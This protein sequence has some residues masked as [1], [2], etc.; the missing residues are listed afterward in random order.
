MPREGATAGASLWRC[1]GRHPILQT[2]SGL[3]PDR[4]DVILVPGMHRSGTS[5]VTGVLAKL[6]AAPPRKMLQASSFNERGYFESPSLM[7]FHD[8]LLASAG[9]RWDDWQRLDS[10]WYAAP[11]IEERKQAAKELF[12]ENFGDE[13]LV[14]LKDPR[15]CRFVPFW[16]DVLAQLDARPAA[17]IPIR[18]PLEVA[19]SLEAPHGLPV[20]KGLLLWL[21]YTLDAEAGTRGLPRSMF[22]WDEF[23]SDWRRVSQKIATEIGVSWPCLSD[24][25]AN[26]IEG[27]LSRD[28]KHQNISDDELARHPDM[29]EW[30]MEAY[31]ALLVLARN[32]NSSSAIKA[33]DEIRALFEKSRMLLAESKARMEPFRA[34]AAAFQSKRIEWAASL[35]EAQALLWHLQSALAAS[36]AAL[37]KV[38]AH[39]RKVETGHA[40]MA[41]A[42]VA[43]TAERIRLPAL[44]DAAL[45]AGNRHLLRPLREFLQRR[46]GERHLHP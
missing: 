42:P 18:S 27:F 44:L 3:M 10:S 30:T 25:T 8:E 13:L 24:R 34:E 4:R 38:M 5:A 9:L 26:E 12:A 16:I 23:L 43:S 41:A 35:A 15:I 1:P 28:L 29:H 20:P 37:E 36:A 33:L 40:A 2:C 21:R 6:G 39:A 14:V 45:S 22:A 46:S 11:H 17:V 7:K 31:G 32:R 19:R